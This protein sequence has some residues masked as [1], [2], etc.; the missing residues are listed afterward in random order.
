MSRFWF[1][2]TTVRNKLFWLLFC[3]RKTYDVTMNSL[4]SHMTK[5]QL[6]HH[7]LYNLVSHKK[8]HCHK[9]ILPWSRF[10]DSTLNATVK[11]YSW[12]LL[13]QGHQNKILLSLGGIRHRKFLWWLWNTW[14]K[15]Y[16]HCKVTCC[17]VTKQQSLLSGV[18]KW[19][20]LE[21]KNEMMVCNISVH[22]R[23]FKICNN[24]WRSGDITWIVFD[25]RVELT[26]YIFR[27]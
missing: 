19:R 14:L 21:S 1:S 26:R 15:T 11:Y 24:F 13:L 27:L 23:D 2:V 5:V 22:C 4:N 6:R 10:E 25:F 20:S 3:D 18:T 9:V 16:L 7:E 8:R 12:P 17:H